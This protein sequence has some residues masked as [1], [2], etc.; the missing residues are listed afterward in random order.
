MTQENCTCSSSA[1]CW[2]KGEGAGK[3][4]EVQGGHTRA[5]LCLPTDERTCEATDISFIGHVYGDRRGGGRSWFFRAPSDAPATRVGD[6]SGL[7]SPSATYRISISIFV[8]TS[9]HPFGARAAEAPGPAPALPAR[10]GVFTA[11]AGR[12]R[13]EHGHGRGPWRDPR[14]A[15]V[16]FRSG[17]GAGAF[18]NEAS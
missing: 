6:F 1:V 16:R 2:C 7:R 14:H 13:A 5:A 17:G 9:I 15:A 12:A 10:G 18:D 11:R 4:K 3:Q 8:C